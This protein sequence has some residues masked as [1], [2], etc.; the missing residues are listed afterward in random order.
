MVVLVVVLVWLVA[1]IPFALRRHSAYRVHTSVARF[2]RQ[3]RLL[4]LAYRSRTDGP[5]T[6]PAR[7]HDLERTSRSASPQASKASMSRLQLRRR[8][9]LSGICGALGLCLV[10]GA[11][12]ELRALWTVSILL[13][14]VL[15]CYL[16]LLVRYATETSPVR[17]RRV[18]EVQD[19]R[20]PEVWV[21][22]EPAESGSEHDD[23]MQR[24]PWVRLVV[25]ERS[26]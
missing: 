24:T 3:H 5:V 14:V 17:H 2:R 13:A 1:L 4:E 23:E 26:A 16:V 7:S 11:V 22:R 21:S 6:A 8:R 12:P 18:H 25:E 20:S 9:V 15:A 10:L 19:S